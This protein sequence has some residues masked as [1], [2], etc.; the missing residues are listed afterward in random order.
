MQ[1]IRPQRKNGC[2]SGGC[3]NSP[4]LPL[5]ML[6]NEIAVVVLQGDLGLGSL[7][8]GVIGQPK[9]RRWFQTSWGRRCRANLMGSQGAGTTERHRGAERSCNIE[10]ENVVRIDLGQKIGRFI[11]RP[12]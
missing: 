8:D 2:D 5:L 10:G 1:R 4:V 6:G 9:C 3:G 11:S 7:I 12:N